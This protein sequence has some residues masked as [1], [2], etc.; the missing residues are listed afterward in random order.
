MARKTRI[1]FEGALYHVIVRGNQKRKVF[2]SDDDFRSYLDI[3]QRYKARYPFSLY[4]YVLMSN[5]I[6]LLMETGK[7]PLN[8][9]LQGINQSY[10]MYFNRKYKTVGHLFQG[11]Y[12]SIL[13]EK[14]AYLLALVKYI[15][16]NPVRAK[17][18]QSPD[19]YLWSSHKAYVGSASKSELVDTEHVLKMFS[20]VAGSARRL[21]RSFMGEAVVIS[22][23]DVYCTVDQRMIG[24][25]VFVEE[26]VAK[27]KLV[28]EQK[29]KKHECSLEEIA[30]AIER[31]RG[32]T[33]E[34]MRS[35][36]RTREIAVCRRLFSIF[37]SEYGYMGKDIGVFLRKDPAMISRHLGAKET[38]ME[39]MKKLF[40]L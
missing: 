27:H 39:D 31:Q 12:K 32:I 4:A 25:S 17:I 28:I 5:H 8:K 24:G 22:K 37:A 18:A 15:H 38:L 13:C 21:Y 1:E 2:K 23:K 30:A 19:D 36:S 10:T 29:R 35:R 6:H 20:E 14:D 33:L 34:D 40:R 7:I 16:L 9:I 11:R 26:T 3:L